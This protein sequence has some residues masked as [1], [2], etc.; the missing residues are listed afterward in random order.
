MVATTFMVVEDLRF[1]SFDIFEQLG[2]GEEEA[3]INQLVVEV[4][5]QPV[6][7]INL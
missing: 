4:I 7:V 5:N 2:V 3:V 6:E 1:A